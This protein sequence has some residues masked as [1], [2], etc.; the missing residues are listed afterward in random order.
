MC[1]VIIT[2]ERASS[3][4]IRRS[5]GAHLRRAQRA[6]Q[7]DDLRQTLIFNKHVFRS[8]IM[9][10]RNSLVYPLR[11]PLATTQKKAV[12]IQTIYKTCLRR[13]LRLVSTVRTTRFLVSQNL[14]SQSDTSTATLYTSLVALGTHENFCFNKDFR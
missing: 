10:L 5:V 6:R 9:L 4:L 13:S 14:S 3:L 8:T 7:P 11:H 1:N 2:R 12:K